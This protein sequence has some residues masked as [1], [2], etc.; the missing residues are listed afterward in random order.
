MNWGA[1]QGA[2]LAY[3]QVIEANA[4]ARSL[5][6]SLGFR[7]AYAYHYRRKDRS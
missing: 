5:Y 3:L 4:A 1:A 7:D 6:A 2:E